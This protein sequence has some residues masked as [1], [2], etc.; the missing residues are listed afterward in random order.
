M[1]WVKFSPIWIWSFWS[2]DTSVGKKALTITGQLT[3]TDKFKFCTYISYMRK[4]MPKHKNCSTSACITKDRECNNG[5]YT[6]HRKVVHNRRSIS[7][8]HRKYDCRNKC[9][10]HNSTNPSCSRVLLITKSQVKYYM[11]H[12]GQDANIFQVFTFEITVTTDKQI[13]DTNICYRKRTVTQL[14]T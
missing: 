10:I 13:W 9:Q 1:L 3:L 5:N 8:L 14:P 4:S 7:G 12:L 11:T 2:R 6:I